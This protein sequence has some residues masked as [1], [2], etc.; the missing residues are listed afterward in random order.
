MHQPMEDGLEDLLSGRVASERAI[1]LES[2]IASCAECRAAVDA[3]R[4]QAVWL[5]SL[6]APDEVSP[7]P[8]FYAR[9]MQNI[10]SQSSSSPWSVFLE[11]V[12]ARRLAF[13][14]LA[15]FVLLSSAIW[16][17]D[18]DQAVVESG[19]INI[20]AGEQM[21]PATGEDQQRDREVVLVNLA[22]YNAPP[23]VL[24][25]ASE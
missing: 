12:F 2:H 19:P 16:K 25:P 8:G 18:Q 11:P 23:A 15:L 3:M 4:E 6:K 20:L 1:A 21:P 14:S 10:E 5:R 9:V 13:A 7:T 22:T 17:T 24:L